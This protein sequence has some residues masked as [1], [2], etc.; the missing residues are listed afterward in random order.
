[1]KQSKPAH[2][3][4]LSLRYMFAGP[5]SGGADL[6][7]LELAK[8]LLAESRAMAYI[9]NRTGW[10]MGIDG[11]WRYE[12]SDDDAQLKLSTN[13]ADW[14]RTSELDDTSLMLFKVPFGRLPPFEPMKGQGKERQ[15]VIDA[16]DA[17]ERSFT[18]LG[19]IL[20]HPT[21]FAAYP[22]LKDRKVE[23]HDSLDG[24]TASFY[25]QV[26]KYA[27]L[28]GQDEAE[29]LSSILHE[30]MHDI[31][32]IEEFA[33]G[34]SDDAGFIMRVRKDVER[35]AKTERNAVERWEIKN[36]HLI[37]DAKYESER[38]SY[39]LMWS[40]IVK[41]R[42]YAEHEKPSSV[43]RHILRELEWIYHP[44]LAETPGA[45]HLAREIYRLPKRHKMAERN[46]F[47]RN[48]SYACVNTLTA[49]IPEELQDEFSRDSRTVKAMVNAMY[50][51]SSASKNNLGPLHALKERSNITHRLSETINQ[52]QSTYEVYRRL[53]GEIEAR[54]VQERQSLTASDR[55]N[56]YPWHTEDI[57]DSNA[58]VIFEGKNMSV[59]VP[60]WQAAYHGSPHTF[61][62]F[63]L[64]GVGTGEGA[65]AYGWGL[66][67]AS[68]KSVAEYY[69][70][71]V[72]KWQVKTEKGLI[73]AGELVE[74]ILDGLEIIP[75]LESSY[76]A[77]ANKY[78]TEI[79][80]GR[81]TARE[82]A[83]RI[84][85]SSYARMYAGLP[86]AI[87][88]LNPTIKAGNLYEVEIPEDHELMDWDK[89]ILEQHESIVAFAK[90]FLDL[91]DNGSPSRQ[92]Y[93]RDKLSGTGE[94]LYAKVAAELGS[95]KDA[96]NA[97]LEAGI[98]G[99][100]YLDGVSR[101]ADEGS[102]N[103]VIWDD[104]RIDMLDGKRCQKQTTP[105]V[106]ACHKPS[107]G[108]P[109]ISI[110]R[111]IAQLVGL[112]GVPAITVDSVERLPAELSINLKGNPAAVFSTETHHVYLIAN[113]I[114]SLEMAVKAYLHEVKGHLGLRAATGG[115]L[116]DVL[117]QVYKSM[118][119][120][121]INK[122]TLRYH[123]QIQECGTDEAELLIAEEY[124]AQLAEEQ[125][126]HPWYIKL[127]AELLRLL[128]A[129]VPGI[130]W[131][132]ED[133]H[134]L[135]EVGCKRMIDDPTV[136]APSAA[137]QWNLVRSEII[138]IGNDFVGGCDVENV[139][140]INEG[141][142]ADIATLVS[143]RLPWVQI[144][145]IYDLEDLEGLASY[146]S[147]F[148]TAVERGDV[149]HTALY[150]AG[151]YFDSE[152]PAGVESFEDLP[153]CGRAL[154]ARATQCQPRL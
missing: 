31:Q 4:P 90:K 14:H 140:L 92:A 13:P 144:C 150:A 28:K 111:A 36:K 7:N 129:I 99:L 57:K 115:M 133:I 47:L 149:G 26:N 43:K 65:Q 141:Y 132:P 41:L 108:V 118:P 152:C 130:P 35:M 151:R 25:P 52:S 86:E 142:C 69:K 88:A 33:M 104:S 66:Y 84:R 53:A 70:D 94:W 27:F 117:R 74:S 102:Y 121:E 98:P 128:R 126:D 72:S 75:N 8:E 10:Y 67:F 62:E 114:P 137:D 63:S 138:R 60:R 78:L 97:L 55:T 22:Q 51:K 12:I 105:V 148:A 24:A 64:S 73:A 143:E 125:P 135:L 39:A 101:G 16:V 42:R 45:V 124:V 136:F 11:K 3:G 44:L 18:L 96:S 85:K 19:N 9:L 5:S 89:P 83:D 81:L 113:Q 131:R 109:A 15:E 68:R 1:M 123:E 120:E 93:I 103:Y 23:W 48:I 91:W 20:H 100:R 116:D 127:A 59:P 119:A 154:T 6:F 80:E 139:A 46:E 40:S 50:R 34:G 122:L 37:D 145:G 54:N 146:S 29:L 95:K 107:A 82:A 87:E 134:A 76:R 17:K 38:A 32:G 49:A 79:I 106:K 112:Y 71:S 21:L 153:Q 58:I 30:V 2:S 147:E 56:N 77:T 110:K 61:D